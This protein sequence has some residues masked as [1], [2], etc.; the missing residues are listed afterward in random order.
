M[1]RSYKRPLQDI[2]QSM[3][4]SAKESQVEIPTLTQDEI[5]ALPSGK[6]TK[7]IAAG[8][9]TKAVRTKP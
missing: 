2:I 7:F 5:N 8:D 1:M 9:P 4:L 3:V 6:N